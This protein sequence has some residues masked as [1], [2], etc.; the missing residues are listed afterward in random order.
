MTQL[1]PETLAEMEGPPPEL[2]EAAE[3]PTPDHGPMPQLTRGLLGVA[4]LCA[5]VAAAALLLLMPDRAM[6]VVLAY[7]VVALLAAGCMRLPAQR[8]GTALGA[9]LTLLSATLLVSVVVLG[10]GVDAPALPMLGL[11][12]CGLCVASGWRAGGLLAVFCAV[13][14]LAVAGLVPEHAPTPGLPYISALGADTTAIQAAL[15]E[16]A[17]ALAPDDR[18]ILSLHGIALIAADRYL[19]VPVPASP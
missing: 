18:D 14:V 10:W 6:G 3:P 1:G 13:G 9:M 5:G 17:A 16:A 8:L 2:A 19:A 7:A 15:V 12:V 4:A 11:A